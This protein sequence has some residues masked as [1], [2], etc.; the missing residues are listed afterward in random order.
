MNSIK[1]SKYFIRNGELYKSC[2][3]CTVNA[4][5]EI[6]YKCPEYFG[7]RKEH[8]SQSLCNK[9]RGKNK[10]GPYSGF[11]CRGKK[12]SIIPEIRLLPMGKEEFLTMEEA[13]K[14]LTKTMPNRGNT[15]YYKR[16]NMNTQYNALILFQ[17]DARIIGYG[18]Y[19]YERKEE[20]DGYK[21]YYKFINNSIKVLNK[22]IT[23]TEMKKNFNIKLGQGSTKIALNYLPKLYELLTIEDEVGDTIV[24]IEKELI[25]VNKVKRF[26]LNDEVTISNTTLDIVP[27][28]E[29]N[30][31]ITD[32]AEETP[33]YVKKIVEETINSKDGKVIEDYIFKHEYEKLSK[34]LSEDLLQEMIDFYNN[35]KDRYGY[36]ILSFELIDNKYKKKY[37]E[38]KSTKKNE[39]APIDITKNEIEFAKEHLDN[40]YIYRVIIIDNSSLKI[41]VITGKELFE[42][43]DLIPT[44]YKIYGKDEVRN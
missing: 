18:F 33:D 42:K 34:V 2:P 31:N 19:E 13:I 10:K 15:F 8:Y 11:V 28:K 38:V 23:N 24:T 12:E 16:H 39:K 1:T 4:N 26:S 30:R 37:I 35:K 25:K 9:C 27:Y 43:F 36:D 3:E 17:Y 21:G 6:Y 41:S 32:D 20:A 7:Y 22:F 44:K 29:T 40:Y 14:F 5:R